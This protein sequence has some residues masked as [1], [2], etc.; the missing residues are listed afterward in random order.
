MIFVAVKPQ[1]VASVLKEV[2]PHLTDNHTIVSIAAGK[3]LASLKAGPPIC[4]SC[5]FL[6]PR[7]WCCSRA[8]REPGK[9]A[10]LHHAHMGLDRMHCEDGACMST[11]CKR[12]CLKRC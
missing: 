9:K 8:A 12:P 10:V 2:R 6:C 7:A 5:T 11:A 3:T 1:F 4:S